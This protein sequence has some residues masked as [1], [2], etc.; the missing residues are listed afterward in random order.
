[1]AIISQN[2]SC[3]RLK[4]GKGIASK[5]ARL[6]QIQV[7]A[8]ENYDRVTIELALVAFVVS[9]GATIIFMSV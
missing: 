3:R 7:E 8:K 6:K 2:G 4:H 5:E 1:M 9:I